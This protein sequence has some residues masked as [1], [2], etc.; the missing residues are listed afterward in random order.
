MNRH[1][2]RSIALQSLYEADFRDITTSNDIFKRHI[3]NINE[4]IESENVRFALELLGKIN[5]NKVEIDKQITQ[6]APDWPME[7]IAVLDRNVLRL[8]VCELLYFDTPPKVVINEAIELAKTYGSQ[9]SS[10]FINGVLG[11][12]YRKCDKYKDENE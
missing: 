2:V 3:N 5:E 4:N 8:A 1:Y 9:K 11:T 7:Q 10:K 12:I 6:A